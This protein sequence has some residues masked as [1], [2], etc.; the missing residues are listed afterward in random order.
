MTDT[1]KIFGVTLKELD[2]VQNEYD[3]E[4]VSIAL[5]LESGYFSRAFKISGQNRRL[6]ELRV[7]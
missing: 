5:E 3:S 2:Q 6:E 4:L 7:K 1:F